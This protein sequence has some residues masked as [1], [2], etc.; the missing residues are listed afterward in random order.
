MKPA[1]QYQ[2]SFPAMPPS[3]EVCLSVIQ[4]PATVAPKADLVISPLAM[5]E[6][7]DWD[8]LLDEE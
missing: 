3:Y 8:S 4:T 6:F 1:P 2:Q 7:F 5:A